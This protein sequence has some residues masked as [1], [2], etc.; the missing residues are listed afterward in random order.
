MYTLPKKLNTLKSKLLSLS[1][2]FT[3]TWSTITSF[4]STTTI[5]SYCLLPSGTQR[6]LPSYHFRG[7]LECSWL[8]FSF[9]LIKANRWG[10]DLVCLVLHEAQGGGAPLPPQLG[11]NSQL[12]SSVIM[13]INSLQLL[14]TTYLLASKICALNG[15]FSSTF[16]LKQ[17]SFIGQIYS[18]IR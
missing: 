6:L 14:P 3:C 8:V 2:R 10:G 16:G 11:Y 1:G 12:S 5:P 9:L 13:I 7:W 18:R 4:I 17:L 15:S